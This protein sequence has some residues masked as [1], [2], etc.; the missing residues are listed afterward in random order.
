MATAPERRVE[1][2]TQVALLGEVFSSCG[3]SL[4]TGTSR[5][6]ITATTMPAKASTGTTAPLALRVGL[7]V[8]VSVIEEGLRAVE[9]EWVV[10]RADQVPG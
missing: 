9:F 10:I 8:V 6:C 5:V 7:L 4:M 3:R 1:V 2:S